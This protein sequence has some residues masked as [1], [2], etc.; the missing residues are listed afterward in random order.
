[1]LMLSSCAVYRP[2]PLQAAAPEPSTLER[3]QIDPRTMPLPDL[4]AHRFD[5]RDGLDMTETA[6]LALANNPDLKLA[7]DDLGISRAQA[8]SAGLLPDPQ[9]SA[10]NDYPAPAGAGLTRAFS[11]GV[12]IDVMAVLMRSSNRHSAEASA[13]KTD[14]GL[15]WQEWQTVAQARQLFL[16]AVFLRRTV[17]LL[18]ALSELDRQRYARTAQAAAAGDLGEDAQTAALSA[19][20]DAVRQLAEARRQQVQTCHDLNALLGLAPQTQPVLVDNGQF[21]PLDAPEVRAALVALPKRRPDLLALEA[22]YQAQEDK[23]RA[24][25]LG[26]FPTLTLGFVRSRDTSDVYTSGF[27]ANLSLPIFNRNRGNIA[28]EH[29]TRQRLR[30][31]YRNRVD[32]AYADIDRLQADNQVLSQQQTQLQAQLPQL[33]SAASHAALA[34][35]QHNLALG[36]YTDAQAMALSKRI[37]LATVALALAQQRVAMQALLGGALPDAYSNDQQ[38]TQH[39]DQ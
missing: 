33:Q 1:M 15:L 39:H 20:Q 37:E 8:F 19:Y 38:Y 10:A 29:A 7:R 28:I 18:E 35:Q 27:Q 3:I 32:Q 16:K 17:P 6:M 9:L 25:I 21:V 5:P 4:A 22:G 24:A 30:D 26:Q 34:F 14:L 23:Y 11:Y 2:E 13:A 36:A 12:S 31:E